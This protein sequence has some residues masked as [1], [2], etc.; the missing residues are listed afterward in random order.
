MFEGEAENTLDRLQE[1]QDRYDLRIPF[2]HDP[3]LDRY[4]SVMEDYRTA[5]TPWFILID[6]QGQVVFND[7][8]LDADRLIGALD[9]ETVNVES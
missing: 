4:P 7:F 1:M 6:P 2:G 3:A 8:S 5:G 9:K